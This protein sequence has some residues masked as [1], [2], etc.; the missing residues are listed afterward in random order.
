MNLSISNLEQILEN[1]YL[2][3]EDNETISIFLASIN[4]WPTDVESIEDYIYELNYLINK[5]LIKRNITDF[6]RNLD[7]SKFSWQAES[8]SQ[9]IDVFKNHE[10]I[11]TLDEIFEGLKSRIERIEPDRANI[12]HR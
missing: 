7:L 2:S 4:D 6:T 11:I 8:L 5:N 1:K 9:I 10:E 3:K 12:R